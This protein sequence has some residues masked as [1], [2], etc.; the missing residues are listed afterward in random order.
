MI[1]FFFLLQLLVR[2]LFPSDSEISFNLK[3]IKK[4]ID[5]YWNSD[6]V[7]LDETGFTFAMGK[8]YECK[9]DTQLKGKL[10]VGRVNSCR[11]GGC[12]Q[13]S[14]TAESETGFEYF[15]YLIILNANNCIELVRVFNYQATHGVEI[16]S[17]NWLKQ[18]RGYNGEKPLEYNKDIDAISGAT[19]SV[20][21]LMT[22]IEAVVQTVNYQNK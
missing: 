15:D 19:V 16:T 4:I 8:L 13:P 9:I 6:E 10:Y 11:S 17:R 7:I 3:K 21:S 1:N 14:E 5:D 12:S 20:I 2:L 18:F 22:D